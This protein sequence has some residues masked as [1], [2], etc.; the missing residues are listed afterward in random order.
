MEIRTIGIDL[1]K[2]TFHL[3]GVDERGK[4]VA[5]KCL[6]RTQL[7]QFTS[8]LPSCLI[9]MEACCGAPMLGSSLAEQGHDVRLIPAQFVKPFVK[10]NKNDYLYHSDVRASWLALKRISSRL[11]K[12]IFEMKNT[13]A[14]SSL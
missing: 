9:G 4:V 8:N 2:K 5:K 1:G 7:L 11:Y 10:G 6:S 13:T 12:L 3:I 14:R